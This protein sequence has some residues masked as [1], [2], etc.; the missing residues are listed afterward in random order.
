MLLTVH[1][2]SFSYIVSTLFVCTS[3][4]G[5]QFLIVVCALLCQYQKVLI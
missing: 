4:V 1:E 5:S 2:T 3:V